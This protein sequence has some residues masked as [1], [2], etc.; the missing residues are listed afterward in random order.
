MAGPFIVATIPAKNRHVIKKEE[1]RTK[2]KKKEQNP[3]FL[4]KAALLSL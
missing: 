1:K 3:G 2:K 4:C